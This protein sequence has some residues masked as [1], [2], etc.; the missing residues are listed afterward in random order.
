MYIKMNLLLFEIG[1]LRVNDN[2]LLKEINKNNDSNIYVFI[3][4]SVWEEKSNNFINMGPFKKKFLKESVINLKENLQKINLH[5]NVFYGNK[6]NILNEII[7]N[8]NIKY[9]FKN[10]PITNYDKELDDN[11]KSQTNIIYP[12]LNH[13][14]LNN[15]NFNTISNNKSIILQNNINDIDI[16]TCSNYILGGETSA[17]NYLK[18]YIKKNI[19][20]D[21]NNIN[22]YFLIN[23]WLSFGCITNK[24]LYKHIY[25][26]KLKNKDNKN[27]NSLIKDIIQ[28]E[29]Y[30]T[31]FDQIKFDLNNNNKLNGSVNTINKLFNSQ[32]GYPFIDAIIKEINTTGRTHV[33]NK[34]IIASFIIN[35]LNLNWKIGF[36]YFNSFLTDI[37]YQLNLQIWDYIINKKIYYNPK[38][39]FIE[40][41]K[42]CFYVKKWIPELSNFSNDQIHNNNIN[43]YEPIIHITYTKSNLL[44]Y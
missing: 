38:K 28:K 31:N 7:K 29:Y 23:N 4:D 19:Y 30:I 18:N 40:L 22:F 17:T 26:I 1:N 6:L 9:I 20:N 25:P 15:S 10:E 35:D 24:I 27:I 44:I 36:D 39:Q 5:L 41:D 12:N 16:P 14:Y 8:Y 42:N 37:N 13:N 34:F 33:K 11:L 2:Y 43:Y 32:T 3:W 21:N